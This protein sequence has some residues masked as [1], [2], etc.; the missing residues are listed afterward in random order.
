MPDGTTKF[1]SSYSVSGLAKE[2]GISEGEVVAAM[3]SPE[4]AKEVQ[5]RSFTGA[6]KDNTIVLSWVED[7]IKEWKW[8]IRMDYTT[9]NTQIPGRIAWKT[10]YYQTFRWVTRI[11]YMD[12]KNRIVKDTGEPKLCK[13]SKKTFDAALEQA[14]QANA[15]KEGDGTAGVSEPKTE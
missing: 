5:L 6:R 7:G 14:K 10:E 8:E 2:L 9:E 13:I 15:K 11:V 12:G 1:E 4:V 3:D